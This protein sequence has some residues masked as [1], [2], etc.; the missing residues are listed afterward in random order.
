MSGSSSGGS[1]PPTAQPC[2][3]LE[4]LT[5]LNSPDPQVLKKLKANDCLTVK[6]HAVGKQKVLAAFHGNDVAGAITDA[7]ASRFLECLAKGSKYKATV[8]SIKGGRCDVSIDHGSC[9]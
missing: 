7:M 6:A 4:I 5:T 1:S 9:E 2:R 3:D 8:I